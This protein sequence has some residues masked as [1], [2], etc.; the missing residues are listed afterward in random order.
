MSGHDLID[1]RFDDLVS[2]L[3]GA[4]PTA[5]AELRERVRATASGRSTPA[6]RRRRLPRRRVLVRV[7]IAAAL[8]VAVGLG[9]LSSGSS[10][11]LNAAD[12]VAHGERV[13]PGKLGP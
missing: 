1:E 4:E 7:P 2:E 11:R 9:A 13:I 8:G 5:S 12:G 6:A 10:P 3:R